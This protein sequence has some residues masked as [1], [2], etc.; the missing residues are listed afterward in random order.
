MQPLPIS[1]PWHHALAQL[2]QALAEHNLQPAQAVVLVPYAQLISNARSS[3][4]QGGYSSLAPRFE[5][6][7]SWPN[8]V[9]GFV[10]TG[11]DLSFDLARDLLIASS[12]LERAGV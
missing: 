8:N 9:A 3:W 11:D 5:T 1:P 2:A 6:T 7:L 12:L 4:Q 10:P